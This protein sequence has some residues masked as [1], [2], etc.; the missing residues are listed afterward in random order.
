MKESE[1]QKRDFTETVLLNFVQYTQ[2]VVCRELGKE[3]PTKFKSPE[4]RLAALS[5][6]GPSPLTKWQPC[7]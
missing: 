1:D 3:R 6:L 4:Q 7:R 5:P 2:V